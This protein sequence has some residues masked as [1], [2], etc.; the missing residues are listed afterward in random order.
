[1][2]QLGPKGADASESLAVAA[3]RH[4]AGQVAISLQLTPEVSDIREDLA[5]VVV[6][7]R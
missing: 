5:K 7:T 4:P 6:L 3:A 2:G 1:M